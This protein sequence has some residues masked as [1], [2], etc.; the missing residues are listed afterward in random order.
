[1]NLRGTAYVELNN[2]P[3]AEDV[4]HNQFG[5]ERMLAILRETRFNSARQVV[6]TLFAKVE[7]HRAGA[8]PNDDL[9]ML[10]L[11]VS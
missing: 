4:Q 7:E 5:D 2:F 6:E 3:L 11:R 1:V 9:T 10:C 8:E